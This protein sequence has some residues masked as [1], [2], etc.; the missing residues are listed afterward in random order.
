MS[1]K[2]STTNLYWGEQNSAEWSENLV[3]L[4]DEGKVPTIDDLNTYTIEVRSSA[5]NTDASKAR[6]A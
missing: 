3:R 2:Q 1:D 6:L 4:R 5:N